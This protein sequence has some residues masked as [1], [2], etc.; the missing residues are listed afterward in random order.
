MTLTEFLNWAIEQG[1]VANPEP[2]N[3]YKGQCVSL[4]QQYLYRVFDKPFS[5]YGNAKDWIYNYPT[6]YFTKLSANTKLQPGDVLV[7]GASYGGGYGHM[8]IVS[9]DNKYYDQNGVKRLAVGYRNTPF[10]NYQCVLRPINQENLGGNETQ[11]YVVGNVYTLQ[12]NLKVREGAGI[13][14][15]WKLRE[16]ITEDGKAN[17]LVQEYATLKAGTRVTVLEKQKI[18]DDIWLR[19][20]SGWIAGIYQGNVYVR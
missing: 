18:G 3:K 4:I 20:P 15:A 7:Y 10:I 5:A 1:S 11:E 2:N 19:I 13:D 17:S 16:N 9:Y 14:K 8:M 6:N 12:V